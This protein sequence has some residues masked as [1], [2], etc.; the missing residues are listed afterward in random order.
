MIELLEWDSNFF[1][2]RIG[3]VDHR[4]F[5]DVLSDDDEVR[6][7]D[8]VYIFSDHELNQKYNLV[9]VKITFQKNTCRKT[10]DDHIFY[11]DL[12]THS[13]AELLELVYLSG[14]DS[15]FLRDEFFSENDFQRLYKTWI[16]KNIQSTDSVVLV[17][18]E[19]H[20]VIGFISFKQ[21]ISLASIDL[22]AVSPEARGKGIGEKLIEALETILQSNTLLTVST[23]KSN[24]KACKFYKKCSFRL[25]QQKFIYHYAVSNTL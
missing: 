5:T 3:K 7:F 13:Y 25:M 10:I 14:H 17:F 9:D 2:K 22:I 19:N 11:F 1:G 6:A 21:T 18:I 12:N 20:K 15:R 16:D 24:L 23:Q 8:L 4:A